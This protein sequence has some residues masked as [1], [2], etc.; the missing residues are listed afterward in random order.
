MT[1]PGYDAWLE[2]PYV[3]AAEQQEAFEH[4]CEEQGIDPDD[5][6]ATEAAWEA[7]VAGEDDEGPDP[8][9]QRDAALDREWDE[10]EGRL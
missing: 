8:D 3:F 2:A 4:F 5:D 9:D 10:R 6:A 1:L 7:F